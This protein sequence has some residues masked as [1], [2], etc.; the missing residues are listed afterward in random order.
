MDAPLHHVMNLE[1]THPSGADEWLCPE[2]GR[3]LLITYPPNYSKTVLVVGDENVEHNGGRGGLTMAGLTVS[4]ADQDTSPTDDL[5]RELFPS[6]KFNLPYR[7]IN[8]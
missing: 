3:R 6:D 4:Q 1:V 2:C 7:S 8:E 5:I